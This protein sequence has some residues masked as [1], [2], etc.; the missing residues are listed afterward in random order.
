MKH[1]PKPTHDWV[2]FENRTFSLRN[3]ETGEAMHS[4]IG[5][6]EEANRIYLD[7]SDLEGRLAQS[8][9]SPLVIYDVGMGLAANALA[10]LQRYRSLK[11][12]NGRGL[13]LVSFENDLSGLRLALENPERLPFFS[14]WERALEELLLKRQWRDA[15]GSV[16]WELRE[17]DFLHAPLGD[18]PAEL[19]YFDFYSPKTCP[20]LWTLETFQRLHRACQGSDSVLLTYSASTSIRAELL[21][22]GFY[23]GRGCSTLAKKETTVAA[24]RPESL[25]DPL[26]GEWLA[27]LK[28][29]TKADPALIARVLAHPQFNATQARGRNL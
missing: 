23:V 24:L 1:G 6:W 10:A 21:F 7:Q 3:L 22:A 9:G 25:R 18:P 5:P 27:K 2:A 11:P 20:T 28:R 12:Q 17:G 13:R 14:G 8:A 29:S 26:G 4:L 16:L 15:T 19:I